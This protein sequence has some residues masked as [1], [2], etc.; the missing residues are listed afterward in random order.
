MLPGSRGGEVL[1]YTLVQCRRVFGPQRKKI[2]RKEDWNPLRRKKIYSKV[3]TGI[4]RT[5]P[6]RPTPQVRCL[7]CENLTT[8]S[9]TAVPLLFIRIVPILGRCCS[10]VL[11]QYCA[12]AVHTYCSNTAV[13]LLFIRTIP[14]NF[15]LY[16][17]PVQ[18]REHSLRNVTNARRSSRWGINRLLQ[19][20]VQKSINLFPQVG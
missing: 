12:V 16:Q 1:R 5:R 3:R 20:W 19:P 8:C 18:R 4:Y 14:D 11:F 17:Y 10:Y 15:F 7:M 13:P 6:S 2:R 9:N